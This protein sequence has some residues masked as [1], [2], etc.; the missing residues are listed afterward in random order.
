[1]FSSMNE[2]RG[3]GE[4]MRLFFYAEVSSDLQDC[5]GVCYEPGAVLSVAD[6]TVNMEKS[7]CMELCLLVRGGKTM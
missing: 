3:R 1:M 7:S 5:T 6:P 2:D 4:V